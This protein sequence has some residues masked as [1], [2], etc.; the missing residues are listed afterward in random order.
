MSAI[1][2]YHNIG[3]T[4]N[5][6]LDLLPT[7]SDKDFANQIRL[8]L[9]AGWNIVSVEEFYLSSSPKNILLTFDDGLLTHY[10]NAAKVLAD[11]DLPGLFFLST[12][13]LIRRRSLIVHELQV[14]IAFSKKDER[15]FNEMLSM[16][17][18]YSSN[19]E[20]EQKK[21]NNLHVHSYENS[22]YNFI[23]K[24]FQIF[25][26]MQLATE[27]IVYLKEK[28]MPDNQMNCEDMYLTLS[29]SLEMEKAGLSIGYHSKSHR[30]MEFLS[31][32]EIQD[33]LSDSE[34]FFANYNQKIKCF[35]YPYGSYSSSVLNAL[36]KL[37]YNLAF[38][39]E[40]QVNVDLSQKLRLGRIDAREIHQLF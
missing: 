24:S 22:S 27:L 3:K 6:Y 32:D 28:Y 2:T 5:K 4:G 33:E 36:I 8:I 16:S 15:L 19:S 7:L 35:C 18:F 37:N 13:P 11:F 40:N 12:N 20:Y 9:K 26:D 39:I 34:S 21:I 1:V 17:Q 31:E 30:W 23:K 14:L 38:T 29:Q 10:K 25:M